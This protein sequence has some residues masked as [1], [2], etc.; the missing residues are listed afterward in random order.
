M[1]DETTTCDCGESIR[2]RGDDPKEVERILQE[3]R[4]QHLH[5]VPEVE[6]KAPA[7][8]KAPLKAKGTIN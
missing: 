5:P 8:K 2:V 1:L 7:A 6:A 4:D 3:F